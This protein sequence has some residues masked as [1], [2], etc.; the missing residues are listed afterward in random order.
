[1]R[2]DNEGGQEDSGSIYGN[3][4]DKGNSNHYAKDNAK[5][6]SDNNSKGGGGKKGIYNGKGNGKENNGIYHGKGNG[7]EMKGIDRG[8][9]TLA[10]TATTTTRARGWTPAKA[11]ATSNHHGRDEFF[12][13][14]TSKI[15]S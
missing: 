6:I 12:L 1:M 13:G 4:C 11:A 7:K 14:R 10:T 3:A 9:A 8:R 2:T 15:P 5:G